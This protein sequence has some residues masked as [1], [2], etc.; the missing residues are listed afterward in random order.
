VAGFLD[1]QTGAN[2]TE[3]L[4]VAYFGRAGDGPGYLYWTNSLASM[5]ASGTPAAT[6]VVNVAN[7]FAVQPEAKAQYAFLASPPATLS[8]TDPVQIA[9]VDSFI[10]QVYQHLFNRAADSAGLTYWQT[11]ILSGQVSVGSAVYAI[12]NGSL[13]SDQGVLADKIVASQSFTQQTYGAN[14]VSG[15]TF[16][17]A[18]QASVANVVDATTLA[19]SQAATTVFVASPGPGGSGLT[20]TAGQDTL[21]TSAVGATFTAPLVNAPTEVASASFNIQTLTTN[22]S[23][24]DSN[25]DGTL[26]A[27]FFAGLGTA[28]NGGTSVGIAS[29][30]TLSGI[31]TANLTNASVPVGGFEGAVT[32]LTTVNDSNSLG[33]IALGATGAGLLGLL[34]NVNISGFVTPPGGTGFTPV[35]QLNTAFQ[36]VIASSAFAATTVPTTIAIG[37]AGSIGSKAAPIGLWF[38]NDGAPGTV[39]APSSG[40]GTWAITAG[41]GTDVLSL[42]QNGVGTTSTITLTGPAGVTLYGDSV[43]GDWVNLKTVTLTGESGAVTITG[44]SSP[45]AGGETGLLTNSVLTAFTGGTGVESV[46]LSSMTAAQLDAMTSLVGAA[47]GSAVLDTLIL[48][49]AVATGITAI[50]TM[51]G[52]AILGVGA[53]AGAL[54]GGTLNEA[55]FPGVSQ[56]TIENTPAHPGET[57]LLTITNGTSPLT[58]NLGTSVDNGFTLFQGGTSHGTDGAGTSDVLTVTMGSTATNTGAIVGG[59]TTDGYETVN[60]VANGGSA[61]DFLGA[62]VATASTGGTETVSLSGGAA[63]VDIAGV[64]LFSAVG[65]TFNDTDTGITTIHAPSSVATISAGTTGG[66]VMDFA[67]VSPVVPAGSPAG[68]VSSVGSSITGAASGS[69]VLIGGLG[70]DKI[71]GGVVTDTI[72]T[73]GGSDNITLG[74]SHN[75]DHIGLYAGSSLAAAPGAVVPTNGPGQIVDAADNAQP[76][77]WSMPASGLAP[78]LVATLVPGAD[79]GNAAHTI[80]GG[81]NSDITNVTGFQAGTGVTHDVLDFSVSAWGGG[82]L[83]NASL[84]HG[85]VPSSALGITATVQVVAGGAPA[86][87]LATNL[88]EITGAPFTS[89][90]D[91][92]HNLATT[93]NITF[94]GLSPPAGSIAH[95]LFAYNDGLGN[96]NIADVDLVSKG[97]VNDTADMTA[98]R[99]SDMVHLVGVSVT[100]L[101]GV[102]VHFV[103]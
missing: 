82:L 21:S 43:A 77:F 5:E 59:L 93:T 87:A 17:A 94:P 63:F 92:A 95:V 8:T 54:N 36:A 10:S 64:N 12:A 98:I 80:T 41:A 22:D 25:G 20:L 14:I 51:S 44:Q 34:T 60:I 73:G 70:N 68:T 65:T 26:K 39:A 76:G 42:A 15:A 88:I 99:A 100:A 74:A 79:S 81:T 86:L 29:N 16:L 58:L 3:S 53:G 24:T 35:N 30:V 62:I 103:T 78:T 45:A 56:I 9:G 83:T 18:A 2:Q 47:S 38:G 19:A 85:T 67:D 49:N 46:D 6:A 27:T 97:G 4:Y 50:T 84:V 57:A 72:L 55:N 32:G 90:T 75:S 1:T 71:V 13:G 96:T 31:K 11:Q 7:S 33:A 37:I 23:L 91:L 28:A 66:L 89:A 102:D 61:T 69:N 101:A 40:Y 52:F 48:S